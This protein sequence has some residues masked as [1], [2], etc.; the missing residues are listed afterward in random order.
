MEFLQV[1]IFMVT[2]SFTK[3]EVLAQV[4]VCRTAVTADIVFLVDESW[5]VGD[6][7]FHIV[8]D[9][10]NSII[11]TFKQIPV[12][13]EGMRFGVTVYNDRPRM[14]IAL[15]DYLTIDEVLLAV[16][17]L[18]FE[19][20]NTKTG[21]A[22]VF[23]TESAFS[24]AIIR[25][26]AP[27]IVILITDGKSAD[28]VENP[29]LTL[30]DH[31]ITAFAVGIKHADKNELKKIVSD[32]FEEHLLYVEEFN[33]LRNLL[34]KISRRLCFTA[35]EPP[36]P[37]KQ[38]TLVKDTII[39]PKDLIVNELS[40]SSL[41][42]T[43][44]PATGHVTGYQIAVNTLSSNGQLASNE[45]RQIVLK[46]N[47]RTTL[48][49]DL[50]PSTEYVFTVLAVYS[51]VIGD[52]T[53]V[54]VKTTPVPRVL[55][56]RVIEEGLFSIRL[57]WTPP[58]GKLEGYKIYI[59][60]SNR[61]GSAYEQILSGDVSS[62]VIDSLVEDKEYTISIYAVYPQ[63]PSDPV[64]T[65]GR[66][67]KLVP[68][69]NLI[70]QNA[71]TD[72]IQA[73]W[74][75]VKGASGYRLT[76]SSSEGYIENLNLGESY[77]FY[78]IQ[79][80]RPGSEYTVTINPI[81]VDIEGPVTTG[82]IKTLTSGAVQTLKA[83]AISTNSASISW[84][85]VPGATGYRL[86]WGPTPEFSGKDRPRQL[87]LNSSTT[88]YQ[89]K[90]LAH[91]TEYVLSLYVLFGS[92]VGPGITATV[93][94]SPLGYV[95]N[96][97]VTSFTRTSIDVAW[98]SIV[99]A[100]EY[101]ISWSPVTDISTMESQ[102]LEPSILHYHIDGL[103]PGTVYTVSI[104]AV[105]GNT[106]GPAITLSQYTASVR[107]SE[108]IQT[109]RD[110]KVVDIGV[111][112]F[113]L[114]WKKTPGVSEYKI[115]WVPFNG[116]TEKSKLVSGTTSFFMITGLQESSAYTIQVSSVVG[117]REASPV[118]LTARTLD[119]PKVTLFK[120]LETTDS[121]ALLN[122]TS[123]PGIS[124][125]LLTWRHISAL[126]S[127]SEF[128]GPFFTSYKITN[129]FYGRTY[130]FTIRPIYGETEGPSTIIT[131][132]ILGTKKIDRTVVGSTARPPS[133]PLAITPPAPVS[134]TPVPVTTATTVSTTTPN[135]TTRRSTTTAAPPPTISSTTR[136]TTKTEPICGKVKA[137]IV[138]LVDE[139]WSIGTNNFNKLKDF[140][141]RIVTYFP[142]IG[143]E[144][145]QVAIVHYSDNPRIEFHLNQFKDRNSVL[146]AIR[147]VHYGGGNTKTGRGIGYVLK[148]VFQ[149]SVG[150]R[151]NVPHLL[152]L[153]T[154]GRAQDDVAP[155][156]RF[157]HVL[158]IRVLAVGVGSA[159]VEELKKVVFPGNFKNVF[160]A[161]T[162]DDF[163]SMEREFIDSLCKEA[164]QTD[165]K[166]QQ[167]ESSKL[168]AVLLQPLRDVQG[169]PS[170][171]E[172]LT[173]PEGPCAICKGQKGEKGENWSFGGLQSLQTGGGFDPLNFNSK[174]EK[175]ERGPAGT[176][177]I[178]GLPGRPGRTGP[179]GSHGKMGPPGVQGHT[180]P[181]GYPGLKGQRGERGDPGYVLGGVEGVQV[182]GRK[183]EPGSPGLQGE[184][185]IPGEPGPPGLSGSSGPQGPPGTSVKG[186]SGEPGERG[187]RGKPGPKGDKGDRGETGKAGLPGPIGLDGSL[188]NPGQKGEKGAEGIGIQGIHGPKG[189]PGQKGAM[190]LTGLLGPTG[191]RGLQGNIGPVGSRGK[192]GL[193]GDRGDKGDRGE[194]GQIG[195][196]GIAGLPGPIGSK[197]NTG[198]QGVPG[199]PA[200]GILGPPG[201]KGVR[202]DLG[203]VGPPGPQGEKGTEGDKG[204]KGSPGFGIPGQPGPKGDNGERGN[205]GL[206]GKPGPKGQDGL[207]GSK[208]DSGPPGDPGVPG[209]RGK[210]G[211][212]GGKGEPGPRG[213]TGPSGEPGEIGTRGPL[214]LPGRPGDPGEKGDTGESGERGSAGPK[215]NKG[216]MGN[217]G[218]PGPSVFTLS[219]NSIVARK[220]KGNHGDPGK[221]G[222]RGETGPPGPRGPEGHP[223]PPGNGPGG[224]G[225]P[226]KDGL[227]G[228]PGP[229]GE[230]GRK[231]EAGG[232]KGEPGRVGEAGIP[233]LPGIP[234]KPG[235][236][237]KRGTAGKDGE[238]GV[239]GE[240]G[241]K[242][243][244]GEKGDLGRD[245]KNGAKGEQGPPGVPGSPV[246]VNFP[247]A[248]TPEEGEK[249]D[250][251]AKGGK[252]DPGP[253]GK[254]IEMKELEKLFD[255][256]GIKLS[257]LRGLINKLLQEGMEEVLQQLTSSKKRIKSEKKEQGYK[258]VN[259]YTDSLKYDVSSE[260]LTEME[261]IEEDLDTDIEEFIPTTTSLITTQAHG[262]GRKHIT[263][264]VNNVVGIDSITDKVRE[265]DLTSENASW[266]PVGG[267]AERLDTETDNEG[268]YSVT[269]QSPGLSEAESDS[270]KKSQIFLEETKETVTSQKS[271]SLKKGSGEKKKGK[272]GGKGKGNSR[273]NKREKSPL[274][275]S[276][277]EYNE[278]LPESEENFKMEELLESHED[279]VFNEEYGSAFEYED[280]TEAPVTNRLARVKRMD[281]WQDIAHYLP[282]TSGGRSYQLGTMSNPGARGKHS[283]KKNKQNT[284]HEL[285][286]DT[287]L[288]GSKGEIGETGQK[289]E[290]GTGFR[291]PV[292]QAGPPGHK[293]EP[294]AP[295][296]PGVQGIQGIRGNAGIPGSQG[297]RGNPGL[298]GNPGP[299]GDR[300]KRGKNGSP[301][302]PG[303]TGAPG[304]QSL[305]GIPG[306]KGD[307]GATVIGDPG[308]R[309]VMGLIGQRGE[310]GQL[311]SRG[312]AGPMGLKGLPGLKGNKGDL[313]AP[314]YKGETGN[315]LTMT[316]PQGY[317]GNKGV[318]GE[319]GL[320]GFDGDKGEK[321]EDGPPGEKGLKGEPGSKGGM[322]P[323]GA[324]GPIGQKGDPG[325]AG[326]N[327][328]VGQNGADGKNGSKGAK[329]DRGLQ[330]QKG[331]SGERGDPG[332]PGDP[333]DKGEK[334]F[335]GLPGRIGTT[336]ID[337]EKGDKGPPGK[338]GIPGSDGLPGLKG[339]QGSPGLNATPG[340]PGEKGEKSSTGFPGFP[341]F[342]GSAGLPGKHGEM[343]K[344]GPE[345][346]KG[347]P[348]PKGNRGK[349]GRAKLCQRGEPGTPGSRGEYGETGPEGLKGEKGDP[350]LSEEDVKELIMKEISDKCGKDFL[351][352][353][354]SV[355][356]DQDH[357]TDFGERKKE[358]L[359][360]IQPFV[361]DTEEEKEYED[362]D[363]EEEEEEVR[364]PNALESTAEPEHFDIHANFTE[365]ENELIMEQSQRKKR[366]AQ[367]LLT[368]I[369]T[370]PC[371]Q[372]MNEGSCFHYTLLW[373]Y[374]PK[375]NECRPF[376]YGGCGG[377]RN[378][379]TSKQECDLQC[380]KEKRDIVPGR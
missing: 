32:P 69:K 64:S 72:S 294:G 149:V 241:T 304:K 190:G 194:T 222:P 39:G 156:A 92:I 139:S 162:F 221:P 88:V 18:P 238:A 356:P 291:G 44:T 87:A 29:A 336:G 245:G 77:T 19:G 78:M 244:K 56:F 66:T 369:F 155:P 116:G 41:R 57:A 261:V 135:P 84:N 173:K 224:S 242:G 209:L 320:S 371:N 128:L 181:Q 13:K 265:E 98:S 298:P 94:T 153:V 118:L 214:G 266:S 374:H 192:K 240:D 256:Y 311:G 30:Q 286:E 34:P 80:L 278:E 249:G 254:A 126:E 172:V 27:K 251:G 223:G 288:K 186:D 36:R 134:T 10:I 14:K 90:N 63:G 259:E 225:L 366:L 338:P 300:G 20:G 188:G 377:N 279:K 144:G 142:K 329:G 335:R 302:S 107:D 176:D 347:E 24:S 17:D 328:D 269:S 352:V 6:A 293:G 168:D 316:G 215:G 45:Q 93:R 218:P 15:T 295:G 138:F 365:S 326:L 277:S 152:V 332:L 108:S 380:K 299:Q 184:P 272:E 283:R 305:R 65:S 140:L 8:K 289:G 40:Y 346:A 296:P 157:A 287:T 364:V 112:S 246:L 376:V 263:P 353:V 43:W 9:F 22:L 229:K 323:F 342:K 301:G 340:K 146:R 255:L 179:P 207:I 97:K 307:K 105:Y 343:G 344:P 47:V 362:E 52:S 70:L 250:R 165:D 111:N 121:S 119:L 297:L 334:G 275:E 28:S 189:E 170:V 124:G 46:G 129:L 271:D 200:K 360:L 99:G 154:D 104:H 95:S 74:S 193:K 355:N 68:V 363:E 16:R 281:T 82:N 236:D 125:Y 276:L 137:D 195:P 333:G 228:Q 160:F 26:D 100:T 308:P 5:S 327:G 38:I 341:G 285:M 50:M 185:G 196:Q 145:T 330:G 49:T 243:S 117:G 198:N 33:L 91:D 23:L 148:E 76:W 351:L 270:E 378:R 318:P 83:T 55:N 67:L 313:G 257:L 319:I 3:R 262:F 175:G 345:G 102:Y 237:G 226:G 166:I 264:I 71:T 171:E 53:T 178:P 103:L 133:V 231:G 51:D 136:A 205:V 337:G 230:P 306:I 367:S 101:K 267:E 202:G 4:E 161:N 106:E 59:P 191:D 89:L 339:K 122:W 11:G 253:P 7:N 131:E 187:Q 151:Q 354:S 220:E 58:L 12:G 212:A 314:G 232:P 372:P 234:G 1:W 349:R 359:T 331:D 31:G 350:G 204:Q 120:V 42:L 361:E 127:L 379:F 37:V 150:M 197:G 167:A 115:S 210:D 309:G 85:S 312:P 35:S 48:I 233:G 174:G 164:S 79:G 147:A 322:G 324:R 132:R 358:T 21:E 86:A 370:H 81:F 208:G 219:E 268:N 203:P 141:F 177:G 130:M 169:E 258:Q 163:P 75:S 273:R 110:L 227:P 199:E 317:K 274:E 60:R 109:V 260:P 25:D 183:G 235:V 62:H 123:V 325:E 252:G 357:S 211:E 373:Y 201:K 303:P 248:L 61:P 54:K 206:S 180:G 159:D 114:S 217:P 247:T 284:N 375:S 182:P 158:G 290:P 239:P 216:D 368:G 2:L 348:G 321:G 292:G 96:F 315:P 143:P 73:R 310:K 282:G 213:E 113:T 280:T